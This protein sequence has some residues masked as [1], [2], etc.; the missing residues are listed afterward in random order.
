MFEKVLVSIAFSPA[1]EALVSALPAMRELGTRELGLVHVAKRFED[2]VSESLAQVGELR[3]RL[4]GLAD[5]LREDGFSVTVNISIG[6]PAAEVVKAA[7]AWDPDVVL[8]GSGSRTLIRDAFIGSVAWDIVRRVGR[9]VLLQKIEPNLADPEAALETRGS[10]L[11]RHV[12]YPTDFSATAAWAR[13]WVLGL[14][15]IGAPS[16]TLIHVMGSEESRKE[17]EGQLDELARELREQGATEVNC[18]VRIGTPYKEVLN[19]GGNR[20]DAL[21]VMGTHGRGFIPGIVLG[22]VGRQ[23]VRHASSRVLLIPGVRDSTMAASIET[24]MRLHERAGGRCE[25]RMHACD[26]HAPGTRCP[27]MLRGRWHAHHRTAG[28]PA[29]LGNLTAMCH[30]CHRN[31]RTS[32]RAPASE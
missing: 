6:A 4:N 13:P 28:G 19:A 9:P 18:R 20:V 15:K 10:G 8:V 1:T 3:S 17:A 31:T 21:V 32:G 29:H 22:S 23:V 30:T 16:F 14:A 24:R 26:H 11:P 25:C 2:P 12:V 27:H 5:R 7:G